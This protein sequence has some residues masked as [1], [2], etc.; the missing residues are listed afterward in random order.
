MKIIV[1]KHFLE[2]DVN[3]CIPPKLEV[4][5]GN[6]FYEIIN[7][8]NCYFCSSDNTLAGREGQVPVSE[9]SYENIYATIIYCLAPLLDWS[10]AYEVEDDNDLAEEFV[11]STKR[12]YGEV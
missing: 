3:E 12:Y 10:H 2:G 5:V 6:K 4:E 7:F 8:R 9:D 1:V 11:K